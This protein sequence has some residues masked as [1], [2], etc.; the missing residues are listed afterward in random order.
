VSAALAFDP[1]PPDRATIE[2]AVLILARQCD[3][4]SSQDSVGFSRWDTEWGHQAAEAIARGE[5]IPLDRA[6]RVVS[7]YR[8]QLE[9]AGITLPT[10]DAL[11]A[12]GAPGPRGLGSNP[13]GENAASMVT[14]AQW[15]K[16]TLAV[17]FPYDRALVDAVRGLPNRKFD[18]VSKAWIVPVE[19]F[20]AVL[21]LFPNAQVDPALAANQQAKLDAARAADDK[22]V[23]TVATDIA[24]YEA[25]LPT[26]GRTPF[27]HQDTGIRWLIENRFG[28][29]A[30][31]MGL[32]KTLQALVAARALGHRIFVICPAGLR[33][34]WL[35]EAEAVGARVE[36]FSWAKIPEP[37]SIA[38]TVIAD[39]AHYAQNMKAA[40][41]KKFLALAQ[42]ARAA[43]ALS[44][45][46]IKNGRPTNLFPLLVATKHE[47]ARD[48][49]SYERRY[50]NAGPTRWTKWDV[51]G[52]SHLEELHAKVSDR[53]LR[54]MKDE[55]LD[56]PA[57]TRVIRDVE[58]SPD[59]GALYQRSL[60]QMQTEYQRRKDAGEIADADALVMLNHMRHA[61]S[62]AKVEAAVELAEEIIEQGGQVVLFT[63]FLESAAQLAT[64]LHA[65]RITGA[66]DAEQGQAAID[67]FQAGHIKAMV[68]TV[69]AGNVGI[70]LTAAQTVVL[71][72]RPWTPGDAL[73]AEDRLHRIGQ[74]N[75]VLALWLRAFRIDEIIDE[76]IVL[77]KF[78]KIELVLSGE[79]REL[80]A[81]R[82]RSFKEIA[83]ELF[84]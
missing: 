2:Q 30:D 61:S 15:T 81:E 14:V 65:G 63:A 70:T 45:T 43:F 33:I 49:R 1:P 37:L 67:A 57:K 59:A 51:T 79:A 62:V 5:S 9:R 52:A 35:R 71:V 19:A 24:R 72:D 84:G 25:I 68:C 13:S 23:A 76:E 55:C 58:V 16:T 32:G 17:K 11:A 54:R 66:E 39:E 4:A 56:L 74:R 21:E 7:K 48:R 53:L 34:N 75:S 38:Y 41:T 78:S 82:V 69:G 77:P 22:R 27:A 60:A 12:D 28:I 36:V 3:H 64:A 80:P 31:D 73:Q 44:G 18:G 10:A 40:R 47:L 42:G 8:R 46:P 26:L 50:C 20:A 29:L 6:L 83:A